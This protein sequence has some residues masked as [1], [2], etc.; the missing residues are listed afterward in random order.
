MN[1]HSHSAE[2]ARRASET[3][4]KLL[5]AVVKVVFEQGY[6]GATMT[7]IAREAGVT[8]GAIQHYFGDKRVDLMAAVCADVLERRQNRYRDGMGELV[9]ADFPDARAQFKAAYR[10]P[11]TW[12]L[13]EIWIASKSDPALREKV[14]TYLT[15]IHDPSDRALSDSLTA[16]DHDAVAFQTYKYFMRT[17]TRGLALEYSYRRDSEL[18]DSVADF[19]FDA[20]EALLRQ[21]QPQSNERG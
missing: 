14:D 8:R 17:L 20:V 12:F 6:A 10:D 15:E 7:R 1:A 4:Q 2:R 16:E 3:S 13:V 18:F 11:E 9:R 21:K 19:A 5:D